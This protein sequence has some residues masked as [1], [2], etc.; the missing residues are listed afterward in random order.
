MFKI[1]LSSTYKHNFTLSRTTALPKWFPPPWVQPPRLLLT[2]SSWTG[3]PILRP[4]TETGHR[5][6]LARHIRY[7]AP[8]INIMSTPL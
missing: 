8:F 2:A 5:Q 1:T 7:I 4:T 6:Y 3:I